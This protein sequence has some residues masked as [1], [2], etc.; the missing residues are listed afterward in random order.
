MAGVE[1]AGLT[2]SFGGARAV[3]GVDMSVAEGAFVALLGP[4]GCGKTTLLRLIAGLERPSAGRIAIGGRT[5]AGDGTFVRPEDRG[6]GMVFQSYALWPHMNVAENV[7]FGLRVRGV[8]R[9]ERE[10]RIAEALAKVG[11]TGFETRRPAQL[12]GGQRQRVALARCLAIRPQLILLDEPLANLDAHLREVMQGEFRRI[13]RETGTTVV[14]VTHDQGEAMALADRIAVMDGGR[15]VHCAAPRE[16]YRRPATAAMAT[17]IGRTTLL[18]VEV[19]GDCGP[20]RR[21]VRIAG[22]RGDAEV[23]VGGTL[24]PGPGLLCLRPE[25]VEIVT[26]AADGDLDARVVDTIFRGHAHVVRLVVEGTSA[27]IETETVDAPPDRAL[28][29][30]RLRGGWLVPAGG[31]D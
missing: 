30:I 21:R 31:T 14:Y 12:S 29:R 24:P 4:S 8:E 17:F 26:A 16:I 3:D 11:L 9:R 18:P 5:M 28:V 6:L 25:D 10:G 2:K 1:L 23:E 13:H 7:A 15:L 20:E 22:A 19:R 27:T